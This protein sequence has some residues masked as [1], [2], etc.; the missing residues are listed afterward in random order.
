VTIS[1]EASTVPGTSA[2]LRY[3]DILSVW[4]LLHGLMLPSGNDAA[5]ALA[6]HFGNLLLQSDK[7][8]SSTFFYSSGITKTSILNTIFQKDY[9]KSDIKEPLS[10]EPRVHS[11]ES[12]PSVFR[13]IQEMNKNAKKLGMS[14]TNFDSPHGLPNKNNKST[15]YDMTKLCL[16]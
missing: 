2:D 14:N 10:P 16:E 1:D 3:N 4:D 11:Y 13:F 12:S 7:K 6:E 9:T 5:H 8:T 15:S